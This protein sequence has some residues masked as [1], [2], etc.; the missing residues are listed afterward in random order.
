VRRILRRRH[1]LGIQSRLTLL[2]LVTVLPL[3][4]LASITMLGVVD[5]RRA[6]I[7][8]DVR[9]R[10]GSFLAD[11][12]RQFGAIQAELQVLATSPSLQTGDFRA[13]DEQMRA[14]LAIRGASIVLHDTR[15]Q[16]L[17]STARLFGEPLPRATNTEMLDRVVAVGKPQISDLIMG[18]VLRRP[19]L[20]V[21]VPVFRDGQ[22][23]YVLAMGIGPEILAAL[24]QEQDLSPD[25]I[26]GIFDRKGIIVARNHEA[27][28]FLG[29]PVGPSLR[30]AMA[31]AVES[32]WFPSVTSEGV[33]VYSTFRR[34]SMTGWTVAIGVPREFVDAPL[35]RA[36]SI[37]FGGG[38]AALALSL[39][40][41]RWMA[42][43]I[44]RPVEALTAA[45]KALGSGEPVDQVSGGVRELD[46]VGD[47][48]RTTAATLARNREQLESM[49]A[50]RTY[51]LAAANK[52]LRAEIDAREQAQSALL[53]AQ[54]ME[55]MGQLTGGVSHDFNNLLAA[56]SGSLSLLEPRI[57][58]ESSLRLLRTAQHGASRGAQLTE[59]LLAFARKQR[60]DPVAADLNTI[61]VEITEMLSRSIGPSVAISYALA[62]G[63][64][65]VLV[66]IGQIETALLNIAINARDAMPGGGKLAIETV[67]I[68]AR[69]DNLPDELADQDCVLV[70][71]HDTG[72]GMSPEV[73]ERAF[74][75]FF[76]TKEIG[77]GTGLGLSM[78]FGVVTQ[79]GGTVRMCSRLGEGTTVQI[80][81]PRAR[82]EATLARPGTASV[83]EVAGA[84]ILVVD[85]DPDVRWVIA[86]DLGEIGCSVAEAQS[87]EDALA[88]LER[89]EPCDL[90]VIDLVMPGL[91]GIDTIRLARCNR[92][93]L[94]VLFASGYADMSRFAQCLG[95]ETLIKKPFT[96]ETLAAAVRA[97]LRKVPL[98]EPNSVAPQ[99]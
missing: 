14:A 52:R 76:T 3:V 55:A 7:E 62:P 53:Q 99:L 78:V 34:S 11:V 58:D 60:L 42:G 8:S 67:N 90:I 54:K 94:K 48:L 87:G 45:T 81:L 25:W 24:L 20:V 49:V 21:G 61:I 35:R 38:A 74:E 95:H 9:Q 41:A 71:M 59:S 84:H 22:V 47:A 83:A 27:D 4:A 2:T 63:L 97:A 65:P 85:D 39:V 16:Q 15:G 36:R 75:P 28:R 86:Q 68:A 31:W 1:T 82:A 50:E 19:I 96:L 98:R 51:E 33:P 46:Q 30:Q 13:F 44:R 10:I 89:G 26:A 29:K 37:I 5:D 70:A 12:D 56:I 91:S 64:W 92:P 17:L 72:T 32:S 40:L 79:S 69:S 77:R 23:V 73:I 18:A 80:Y 88:I 66:D 43:A 57:S 93:D 6:Q